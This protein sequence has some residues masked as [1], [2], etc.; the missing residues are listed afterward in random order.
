MKPEPVEVRLLDVTSSDLPLI[1]RWLR[2]DHVRR[3]WGEPEENTRLLREPPAT[4]SGRA[5]IEAD[6]RK[7]G[8]VLW[9]HPTRRELDEAGLHDVPESV[10]DIDIMIGEAAHV[11][12]GVG[13]AAIRSVA[14][15]ALA[16][17]SVPFVIA[18]TLIENQRSQRAF[19]KAGFRSD[20]EF[21]DV[22]SGRCVLMVR[23]REGG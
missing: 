6:G 8:L 14:E 10:I 23:R 11:G 3:F 4:G 17:A 21:D 22:P 15:A 9:Q 18:G 5:I 16:D 13:P 1:E 19:A 2:E 7:V 12:R 20:R